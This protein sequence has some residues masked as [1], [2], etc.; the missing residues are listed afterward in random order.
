MG[1]LELPDALDAAALQSALVDAHIGQ[2][3]LVFGEVVST[4]DVAWELAQEGAE[5]GLVVL[6]ER[7]TAGRGQRGRHWESAPALGLW[8]SILLRPDLTPSESASLTSWAAGAIAATIAEE[9]GIAAI[10]KPPNDVYVGPAKVAGVLVE[11][12]VEQ[13]GAYAAIAGLG[14][15]INQRAEDFSPEIRAQAGSLATAVGHPVDRRHF[16]IALLRKLDR[17]YCELFGV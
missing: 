2:R 12:R 10:I 17:S 14:V 4:N 11:M 8:G 15:N 9:C 1:A 13:N 3:I 6:A 7:Q 16:A 5:S